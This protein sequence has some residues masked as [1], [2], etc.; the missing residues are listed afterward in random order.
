MGGGYPRPTAPSLFKPPGRQSDPRLHV[1]HHAHSGYR[2]PAD[3]GSRRTGLWRRRGRPGTAMLLNERR[4]LQVPGLGG[5]LRGGPKL[6]VELFLVRA[7]FE[8]IG[9][10]FAVAV[11]GGLM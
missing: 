2:R 1:P 7:L 5:P 3:W 11:V 8:Q 10:D 9:G 6:E 4:N